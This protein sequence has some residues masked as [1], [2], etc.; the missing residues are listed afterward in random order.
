LDTGVPIFNWVCHV[1]CCAM[2]YQIQSTSTCLRSRREG[3]GSGGHGVCVGG[4]SP[5]GVTATAQGQQRVATT[6][7]AVHTPLNVL[8]CTL[9]LTPHPDRAFNRYICRWLQDGFRISFRWGSQLRSAGTNMYLAMEH[10]GVIEKYLQDE[11]AWGR[12]LG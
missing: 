5:D 4:G 6:L 2:Y 7:Q 9:A 1:C 3:N 10:P 12:V 11:M 8:A